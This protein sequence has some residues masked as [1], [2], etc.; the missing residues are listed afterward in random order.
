MVT[1]KPSKKQ[2]DLSSSLLDVDDEEIT[3]PVNKN[4]FAYESFIKQSS[5]SIE[6]LKEELEE[7][8]PNSP[9]PVE[10]KQQ[11][12][13]RQI[14]SFPRQQPNETATTDSGGKRKEGD[15]KPVES[16]AA[17]VATT[18]CSIS[19][20]DNE[21]EKKKQSAAAAAIEKEE[22]KAIEEQQHQLEEDSELLQKAL[23]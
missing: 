14:V 17:A 2:D 9:D 21:E 7:I 13:N 18:L 3:I 4:R 20:D 10:S 16:T 5:A 22:S 15:S 1:S 11:H 23:E 8:S 19:K 12:S 6:H